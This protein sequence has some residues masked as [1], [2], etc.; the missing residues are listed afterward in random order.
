MDSTK[1][2]WNGTYAAKADHVSWYQDQ[3]DR[4]LSLIKA[5]CDGKSKSA[6]DIGGGASRLVD[7]LLGMGLSD[8][9]V[10]DISEVALE[11][12]R[13][14]LGDTAKN[15]TWLVADLLQW[16][17]SR[18]WDIWHDRAV[19]HFLTERASQDAYFA[20]LTRGTRPGSHIVMATFALTGPERCSN[21]PVQRYSHATLAAR[22]G[23]N[24]VPTVEDTEQH[25]TPFGTTQDFIYSV[26]L[27]R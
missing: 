15:I 11:R 14:R 3:P 20:A 19:F 18:T 27:R 2:H 21:L 23:P 24:F 4:S 8:L 1:A 10:L 16:Q 17:P 5:A 7:S 26:F 13:L 6:I 25:L 9:T 22:L 12:S